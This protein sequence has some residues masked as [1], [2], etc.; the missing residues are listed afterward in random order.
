[1]MMLEL[2]TRT[3]GCLY[4]LSNGSSNRPGESSIDARKRAR[5]ICVHKCI[6]LVLEVA[7]NKFANPLL[8]TL[9]FSTRER[10]GWSAPTASME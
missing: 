4:I 2:L 6:M 5:R 3:D 7:T 10:L 1:M 9:T 8:D